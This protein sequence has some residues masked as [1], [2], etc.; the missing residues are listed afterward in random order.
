MHVCI[1]RAKNPTKNH[2][3]N[4]TIN[5]YFLNIRNNSSHKYIS[6]LVAEM[7]NRKRWK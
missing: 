6:P 1:K 4:D 5:F 2:T 7:L 3:E